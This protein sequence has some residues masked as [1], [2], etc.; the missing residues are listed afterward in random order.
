MDIIHITPTRN[1]NSIFNSK[2][3]RRKPL[4][5]KINEVM[6]SYYGDEYDQS[7]GLVFGF[8]E[9][10]YNRDKLIKDFVYWKT[11]GNDRNIFLDKYSDKAFIEVQ[12]EGLNLFSH[13]I[14]KMEHF[15]VLLLDIDYEPFFDYYCHKQANDMCSFWSDMDTRYEHDDK[16]LTLMNYDININKIKKIIGTAE[17]IIMRKNKIDV[18]LNI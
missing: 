17:S 11:W 16:P 9:H 12:N 14:P 15:S 18:S 5:P 7:K 10:V 3:L 1:I 13:I 6:E 2:I 4:L 8:P